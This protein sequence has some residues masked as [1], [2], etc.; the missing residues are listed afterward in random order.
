M[1]AIFEKLYLTVVAG[2]V[3]IALI[4]L[5]NHSEV[6]YY[7]DLQYS[8]GYITFLHVISGVMWIGLLWYFNFVQMPSMPEIPAELKPAVSKYIAPRAL[9]WFRYA[10]LATVLTGLSIA[11][12]K[13]YIHEA[14]SLSEPV[15]T[16]GTG[17]YM[18]L[19]MAFNVWFIIWPNQKKALGIVQVSDAEK[20]VAARRAMLASRF[21]TMLSLPMLYCMVS[22]GLLG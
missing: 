21:N 22:Q 18:A 6:A 7:A 20:A 11:W 14:L 10:A 9:L 15:V 17:M 3:L 1:S 8:I 12:M 5:N 16:I 2:A 13:G 19:L 4:S